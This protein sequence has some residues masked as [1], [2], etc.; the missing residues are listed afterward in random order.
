MA[1][2]G[3]TKQNMFYFIFLFFFPV[4]YKYIYIM[5]KI[6]VLAY[7]LHFFQQLIQ[8]IILGLLAPL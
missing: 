3:L 2:K 6:S 8:L 5:H 7:F 4:Q 1:G